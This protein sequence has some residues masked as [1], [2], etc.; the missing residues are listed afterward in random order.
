[1]S[2]FYCKI[3]ERQKPA[4]DFTL[5][6]RASGER[7]PNYTECKPCRA[8]AEKERRKTPEFKEYY[9]IYSQSESRK[10]S[11][12]RRDQSEK[13]KACRARY[14]EGEK[15]KAKIAETTK[16]WKQQPGVAAV[17]SMRERLRRKLANAG[18]NS[19][20]DFGFE[21][22]D[23]V[24][25]IELKWLPGMAWS[26]YGYRDGDYESGWDID[27]IIP[28]SAFDHANAEDVRR[29]WSLENLRP[30]WHKQN[31]AK[32]ANLQ[33]ARTVPRSLWPISWN[34]EASTSS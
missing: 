15:G 17:L 30:L 10:Q 16:I 14:A 18:N 34:D 8:A 9:D 6:L 5:R 25:W 13:G 33:D 20:Y 27:H 26:N 1:M 23:L 21:H 28:V 19:S 24:Q 4:E 3:C 32:S 22:D 11:N 29:C 31:L 2:T 12:K 7:T